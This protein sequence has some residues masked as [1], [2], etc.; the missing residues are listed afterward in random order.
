MSKNVGLSV[1]H[2]ILL[3]LVVPILALF[4]GSLQI[5]TEKRIVVAEMG[6]ARELVA[7]SSQISQLVHSLQR[8]RGASA[9]FVGSR[10]AQM[11]EG[12]QQQRRQT[13][14]M[15]L[16]FDEIVALLDA[17]SMG[18]GFAEALGGAV[19]GMRELESK[20]ERITAFAL[21]TP[22]LIAYFTDTIGRLLDTITEGAKLI[23]SSEISN[24]VNAYLFF[25]QGKERAGQER[26]TGAGAF[27]SGTFD[28]AVYQ[29]FIGA[30]NDQSTYFRLF[31]NYATPEQRGYFRQIVAGEGVTETERLRSLA[32]KAGAG[33]DLQKTSGAYWFQVATVRI[34]LMKQV[35]DRLA[36][37]LKRLASD[38][39]EDAT[40]TFRVTVF[41]ALA[42]I[43][44]AGAFG[45]LMA[46]SIS[47]PITAMISAM[48]AL[49]ANDTSIEIPAR[50]RRDEIGRMA[51]SVQVFKQNAIERESLAADKDREQRARVSRQETLDAAIREYETQAQ[52]LVGHM[53]S[54]ATELQAAA[55]SLSQ[56]AE[57]TSLQS[58]VVAGASHR[59]SVNVQSAAS[60]G[61]ELAASIGEIGRQAEGSSEK[62]AF[63]VTVARNTDTKVQELKAAAQK[64]E[65][66]IDLI[67]S[68]A[69][70]TNLLALN[71]TIEA[72]RAGEAGRG[73]AVVASEVKQLA[74]NTTKATEE[75]KRTVFGVR[76]A[77]EE[78]IESIQAISTTIAE[79]DQIA[80]TITSAV[81]E[82]ARATQEIASN[83]Q[84]AARGTEDVAS[85]V[86]AVTDAAASTGSA[87]AQVLAAANELS[88]QAETI[89]Y[90]YERFVTAVRAA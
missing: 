60:A 22:E 17:G 35:E 14:E 8:E 74:G 47:S 11:A 61:E 13:D 78:S 84:Q 57:E 16:R 43:V 23:E 80:Q 10:G 65:D 21:T 71:A 88:R 2:R 19:A 90:E 29:R 12:L 77:T 67:N 45:I 39:E 20:R 58:S 32:T 7:L 3:I 37:D 55:G 18:K 9:T 64:I 59:A 46:R 36:D 15:R 83:V 70:Q 5:V 42:A 33:G 73:F 81:S 53:A 38:V 85:S 26:A 41:A 34:D 31:A 89:R 63:A 52:A 4:A 79:L 25:M 82:Q 24:A 54:T 50:N 49:A 66:V 28:Q 1:M 30:G 48:T 6:K 72:A 69:S 68:I 62:A 27:A 44:L 76:T 75:I 86:T 56:A 40:V 87:S 51:A